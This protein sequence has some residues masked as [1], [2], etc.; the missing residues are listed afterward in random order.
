MKNVKLNTNT[1]DAILVKLALGKGKTSAKATTLLVDRYTK[2]FT[3]FLYKQATAK[4]CN[5]IDD[6]AIISV[7]KMIMKLKSYQG[8]L[9]GFSTWAYRIAINEF[10]DQKRKGF[11]TDI[12]YIEDLTNNEAGVFELADVNTESPFEVMN[13]KGAVEVFWREAENLL[14]DEGLE[15]MRL[16]L[17]GVP[18]KEIA[19]KLGIEKITAR[20]K[21]LRNRDRIAKRLKGLG[22]TSSVYADR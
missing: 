20:V 2:K 21:F 7:A 3:F 16:K 10:I 9:A 14:S 19:E 6:I 12:S 22:I 11:G 15:L 5:L 4:D 8:E 1:D 13:S 17:G 18:Y